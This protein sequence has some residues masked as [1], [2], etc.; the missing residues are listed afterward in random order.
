M[1]RAASGPGVQRSRAAIVF[2]ACTLVAYVCLLL[3]I[4]IR[5]HLAPSVFIVAGD[6]FV[7]AQQTPTSIII[8]PHSS[9]YDGQFYYALANNPFTKTLVTAGV[10]FDHPIWR[11]QR[12][13]YPLLSHMLAFGR[14]GLIPTAMLA[15]NLG[16]L[17]A[18]A[19]LAGSTASGLPGGSP[20]LVPALAIVLWPGFMT[21]L[22]HDTT[23]LMACALL[24]ATLR[25]YMTNNFL[26]FAV[27]GAA[28]G[29]TRETSVLV[30]G[31]IFLAG[32]PGLWRAR[33]HRMTLA[34][35]TPTLSA[36]A[37]IVIIL[38]WHLWLMWAWRGVP[39]T[40]A[41][42]ADIG[43][44]FAGITG[45]ILRDMDAIFRPNVRGKSWLLAWN[46]LAVAAAII[47]YSVLMAASAWRLARQ[48]S[49]GA[50]IATGW[51]CIMALMILLS[52][53]GP[54]IE[55][56]AI[57]RAF[58]EAWLVGWLIL[59]LD[60]SPPSWIALIPLPPLAAANLMLCINNVR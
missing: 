52:A 57:L 34:A 21:T 32:L 47:C 19:V 59:S 28:A 30:L 42:H 16:A 4:A 29:L 58:S 37:S 10:T 14:A 50:A 17:F 43:F 49:Q 46:A 31:G 38:A 11:S 8:R 54:W 45:R 40:I 53:D 24:F 13:L 55:P 56:T 27:L 5:H 1:T 33:S 18:I 44:P 51:V 35:V 26:L 41:A 12:I 22:T 20:T 48:S 60:K 25:A 15:A 3:P 36:A 23:E 9:G 7:D 2:A 6:R 39:T